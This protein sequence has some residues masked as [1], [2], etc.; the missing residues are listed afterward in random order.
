MVSVEL[1][2]QEERPDRKV[3]HI[4]DNGR[5]ELQSWLAC[6]LARHQ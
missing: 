5:S 1:V 4:T 2:E 3:Y 6:S